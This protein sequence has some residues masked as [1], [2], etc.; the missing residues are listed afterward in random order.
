MRN[1]CKGLSSLVAAA[2][3]IGVLVSGCWFIRRWSFPIRK[4]EVEVDAV[5]AEPPPV[6]AALDSSYEPLYLTREGV[7]PLFH[8]RYRADIARPVLSAEALMQRIQD[9]INAFCPVELAHFEKITGAAGGLHV[10]DEYYITI[11]GP[12]NGHV[13]TVDVTP[14]SFGFVT[15]REHMERGEIT[16]NLQPHPHR[17]DALRFEIRSWARSQD[18]LVAFTYEKLGIAKFAQASLWAYFCNAVVEASGG[19]LIGEIDIRTEKAPYRGEVIEKRE[20]PLWD[21]H[22]SRF[23]RFRQARINYDP[24]RRHE[25]TEA[26]GWRFDHYSVELTP[27]LP[28]APL[29]NGSWRVAQNVIRNYEFPD[30]SIVTGIFIPDDPLEQRIMILRARFLWFT[31]FFGTRVSSVIDEVRQHDGQDV[32]VWGYS[33]QTLEDH[34]EMGEITFEVWKYAE[35]GKVEFRIHAYS[36]TAHI[37]NPFYRLGFRLFG[38][39]L[40]KRFAYS[41]LKRMVQFVEERT[42]QDAVE[43]EPAPSARVQPASTDPDAADALE[44]AQQ[45]DG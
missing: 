30:P 24:D 4:R 39:H 22:Q 36:K 5:S 45:T 42:G 18:D 34:F 12:W 7:G 21:Q 3:A 28:G 25:Y 32:H 8:R 31:F 2:S 6:P 19:E 27:E 17:P 9:D 14:T 43:G 23:E 44:D 29:E 20:T 10:G 35:S 11:P 15:L 1:R 13:R 33:Y 26:Q 38:R 40:Q 16:F 41:A 37:P